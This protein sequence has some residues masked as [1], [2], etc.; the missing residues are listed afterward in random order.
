MRCAKFVLAR[1]LPRPQ[2]GDHNVSKPLSRL[3]RGYLP[4]PHP[5]QHLQNLVPYLNLKCGCSTACLKPKL[6]SQ[7]QFV[8]VCYMQS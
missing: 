7:N 8:D 1:T 4:I 6:I 2:W 5:I 3:G